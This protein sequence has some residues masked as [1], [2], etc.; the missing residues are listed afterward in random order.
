ME[1]SDKMLTRKDLAFL[2]GVSLPTLDR[3][4]KSQ[5]IIP[6]KIGRQYRF[7]KNV[8]STVTTTTEEKEAV[9]HG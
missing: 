7:P 8:L 2:L 6:I 4:I 9:A 3:F 1:S 5:N